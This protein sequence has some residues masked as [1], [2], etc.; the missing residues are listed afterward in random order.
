MFASII[1][2]SGFTAA[3]ATSL[4]VDQLDQSIAG[5]DELYDKRVLTKRASTTAAF[6][7]AK[8]IRYRTA[9]GVAAALDEL[10]A[11]RADAVV[12][13]IPILRYLVSTRH[14]QDLPVLPNLLARQDYGIALPPEAPRREELNRMILQ[15]I[16]GLEWPHVLATYL[17]RD[18]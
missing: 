8:L 9:P 15:I 12:Y 3:I 18:D 17:G 2:I 13:D 16:Q 4:T 7:D 1:M 10:A 11:G 14:R 5:I 6:L